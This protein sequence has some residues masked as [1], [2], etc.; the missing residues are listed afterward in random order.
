[1]PSQISGKVVAISPA[2]NLITDITADRLRGV[3]R[4]ERVSIRCD[5]HET[6][7]IFGQNHSEPASTLLALIGSEGILELEIVG[8]SAA[9]MLG[10]RKGETVEV[11][12]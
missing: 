7:G 1:M 10:V 8:D 11:V 6:R 9:M 2:G 3:P 4:D 5:E 12:W